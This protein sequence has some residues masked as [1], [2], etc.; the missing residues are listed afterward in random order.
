MAFPAIAVFNVVGCV[1][2]AFYFGWKLTLVTLC[3]SFPFILVAALL[4]LRFEIQFEALNAKVFAESSQFAGESIKAFRTVTSLTLEHT[5]TDRYS[6]LLNE[7]VTKAFR[8]AFLATLIF[9]GS[10]SVELACM[11]FTFWYAF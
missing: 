3:S 9:A 11:A 7:H 8:K 1:I 2:I 5:I 10:D 4:R 6:V